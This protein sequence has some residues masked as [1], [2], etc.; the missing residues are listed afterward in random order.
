MTSQ[1]QRAEAFRNSVE[2]SLLQ[3]TGDSVR[4]WLGDTRRE[5]LAD[6]ESRRQVLTAASY[7]G[8]SLL[9]LAETWREKV[10]D[11]VVAVVRTAIGAAPRTVAITNASIQAS[12]VY[13]AS[14]TDRLVR[15]SHFGVTVY[16]ESFDRIRQSLATSTRDG[17]SRGELAQRIA[18]ELSWDGDSSYWRVELAK[19]DKQIDA[20]LDNLGSPGTPAREAARLGDP[21]IQELR[22]QRNVAIKRLDAERAVWETR[23]MLIART[24][25]TGAA[26]FGAWRALADEGVLTKEW[27]ATEDTRTRETH[28]LADG[29]TAPIEGSFVVGGA[30]MR[31]PGDPM[32]PVGEVANCRCTLIGGGANP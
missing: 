24:E 6:V 30:L 2:D 5:V 11:P 10:V 16:E 17:W 15:G 32:A 25:S 26:G 27:L 3:V 14:V 23:S 1:R 18:A 21:M 20:I 22:N 31:F 13:L 8:F 4:K 29:Q 9:R 12:E 7:D 19:I 28:L